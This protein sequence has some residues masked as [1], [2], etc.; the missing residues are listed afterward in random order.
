MNDGLEWLKWVANRFAVY[1]TTPAESRKELR[2]Q[3][4]QI[5][6]PWGVRWFGM[7]AVGIQLWWQDRRKNKPH[8]PGS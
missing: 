5:R 7:L 4:K 8:V 3:R 1:L 6:E 2:R